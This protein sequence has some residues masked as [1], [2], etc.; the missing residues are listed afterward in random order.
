VALMIPVGAALEARDAV[1]DTL[2]SYSNSR[3]AKRQFDRF[4]RRGAIAL[5]RNRR[6]LERR[7]R[8]AR[9]DIDRRTTEVR[10]SAE[11]LVDDARSLI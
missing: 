1:I 5:R 4:E 2:R 10:T 3:T 11:S 9:R 7:A 6:T 8:D